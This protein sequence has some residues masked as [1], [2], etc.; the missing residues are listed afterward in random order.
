MSC[1]CR[2]DILFMFLILCSFMPFTIATT[3]KRMAQS[4][5]GD[6]LFPGAIF[7]LTKNWKVSRQ[8]ACYF[9]RTMDSLTAR[10]KPH[11]SYPVILGDTKKWSV[12]DMT[13][14][15][16]QWPALDF[17]FISIESA[18]LKYPII[19][20]KDFED[21]KQPLST[22]GYKRMCQFFFSGFLEV[23]LLM[24][25]KYILRM[26]DDTC[27]E[28]NINFDLFEYMRIKRAVYG[29]THTWSDLE[30]ATRGLYNFTTNYIKQNNIVLRNPKL[31]NFTV[32]ARAFPRAVLSFNTNFEIINT[33]AYRN[34]EV[35]K[36][37]RAVT[38]SNM[39][40]HRRWGDAPLRVIL[41][42]LFWKENSVVRL[43]EFSLQH[44]IWPVFPSDYH[45]SDNPWGI[46]TM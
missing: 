8:R 42:Q 30:K 16:H 41:A 15:R 29:F 22:L 1:F 31:F 13:S 23:P 33:V 5:P 25:Y 10:W 39:I 27:I 46:A 26:D 45:G 4:Q 24:E 34:P 12:S 19:P 43:R 28:D 35:L 3:H 44:S 40:F 17:K 2:Y 14:I 9:N 7:I 6:D 38:E 11:N 18:F 20:A 36:F 21:A 32:N 37:L